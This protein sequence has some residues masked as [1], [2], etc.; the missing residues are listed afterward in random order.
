MNFVK[1]ALSDDLAKVI[2]QALLKLMI[3]HIKISWIFKFSIFNS[4]SGC[5]LQLQNYTNVFCMMNYLL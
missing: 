3:L 1:I 2:L 4:K 5:M